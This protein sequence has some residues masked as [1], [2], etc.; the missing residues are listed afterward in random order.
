MSID[1]DAP[2]SVRW[3]RLR[4]AIV[5]PLL[6]SPPERGELQEHFDRLA[7]KTWRPPTTGETI[8]F[9]A[10]SIERW[11]YAAKNLPSDPVGAL[12]HVAERLHLRPGLVFLC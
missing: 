5:G 7:T 1:D 11:Y 10:S 3:A 12:A 2:P 8:S 4:F 9:S 6:V